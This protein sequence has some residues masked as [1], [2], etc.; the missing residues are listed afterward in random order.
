MIFMFLFLTQVFD[1]DGRWLHTFG[2]PGR[3]NSEFNWPTGLAVDARNNIYICDSHNDRIQVFSEDFKF[4][5]R[6][7][8]TGNSAG[9]FNK[10]EDILVTQDDLL[11]VVDWGNDRVQ[12]L[13][14]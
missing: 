11:I 2:A 12:V 13:G 1:S 8:S 10:P 7:G 6:I 3:R 4:L 14:Q 5:G 9:C